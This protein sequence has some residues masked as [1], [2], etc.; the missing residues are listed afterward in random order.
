MVSH[1]KKKKEKNQDKIASSVAAYEK[2]KFKKIKLLDPKEAGI[3]GTT[4]G[5]GCCGC[6]CCW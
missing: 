3:A 1:S 4:A 6:C 5:C 2:P